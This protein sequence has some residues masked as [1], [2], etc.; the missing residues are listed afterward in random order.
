MRQ[1]IY[2]PSG[3]AG[4]YANHGYAA[5]LYNGCTN[6]CKYCFGPAIMRRSRAAFNAQV[7]PAP[8]VL[9]RLEYDLTKRKGIPHP[10]P[11][12]LFLCF[13]CDPIPCHRGLIDEITKPAID[14]VHSSGNAV[15]LLTKG[16]A[17][18]VVR[19]LKEGDEYWATLT[20]CDGDDLAAWEPFAAPTHARLMG[21]HDAYRLG[22]TTAAS[23]EPVIHPSQ[24]LHLIESASEYLSYCKIGK[25]NHGAQTDWPSPEWKARVEAIDWHDFANKAARLC[26]KLGL[27]RYIKADL[28][29][30]LEAG[31]NPDTIERSDR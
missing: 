24:T 27:H 18:D 9:A 2:T 13:A 19:R 15:R 12:P 21:L 17:L 26:D 14:I 16:S 8:D 7:V 25:F 4:E 30:Y 11:E 29:P 5:N 22:I 31:V 1:L 10:L 23:F 3:R 20:L 28:R 6:G